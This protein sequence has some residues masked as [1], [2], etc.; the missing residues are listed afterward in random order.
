[1]KDLQKGLHKDENRNSA[2]C[3]RRY[4]K[5]VDEGDDVKS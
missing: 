5:E 1:M 3:R 2:A 4:L